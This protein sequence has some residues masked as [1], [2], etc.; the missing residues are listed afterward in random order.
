MLLVGDQRLK[1]RCRFVWPRVC[2][3]PTQ[4]V[5]MSKRSRVGLWCHK[6]SN[7]FSFFF[8]FFLNL[9]QIT[10]RVSTGWCALGRDGW[11]EG[12]R[13]VTHVMKARGRRGSGAE[14][15]GNKLGI[16]NLF[17]QNETEVRVKL[18]IILVITE[19]VEI[20]EGQLD[21]L[22]VSIDDSSFFF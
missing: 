13:G 12:E 16:W 11:R 3:P 9:G 7:T 17:P 20:R 2:Q 21:E 18:H 19:L 1:K 22:R 8:F 10:V 14:R 15:S 5:S 6:T 4:S